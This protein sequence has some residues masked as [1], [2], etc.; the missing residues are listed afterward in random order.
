[1]D[2]ERGKKLQGADPITAPDPA[3][4]RAVMSALALPYDHYFRVSVSGLEHLPD[5]GPALLVGNHSGAVNSPDMLMLFVAWYR[6]MGMDTP[7]YAL[8]HDAFFNL[9]GVGNAL[10]RMGARPAGRDAAAGLLRAGRFLLVY[11]GGDRDAFKPFGARNRVDFHGRR[12]FLKLALR[13]RVPIIPV[14]ARGGHETLFIITSGRP[15][16]HRLGLDKL[17]RFNQFPL[18]FSLPWG[19]TPGPFLPYVPFP[20]H[21]RI[22]FGAP[23]DFSQRAHADPEDDAFVEQCHSELARVMQDLIDAQSERRKR[24]DIH[25][26]SKPGSRENE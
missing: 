20:I 17:F 24:H 9:P 19:L 5:Q 11:P 4:L 22:R 21:I 13:E 12:G 16:A 14:C 18:A 10:R 8:A 3:L 25:K 7:L 6:H 15:L 23:L 1:M 2:S 26:R